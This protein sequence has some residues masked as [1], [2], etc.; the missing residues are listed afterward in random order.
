MPDQPIPMEDWR[1]YGMPGHFFRSTSCCF[2]MVTVIGEFKVSTIGCYHASNPYKNY[3]TRQPIGDAEDS[4]YETFVFKIKPGSNQA[5]AEGTEQPDIELSEIDGER[6][7]TEAEAEAGHMR[8]CHEYAR[9]GK[10]DA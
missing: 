10:P 3:N 8:Y 2:H 7:A 1:W 5:G 6:W 4:L 9:E